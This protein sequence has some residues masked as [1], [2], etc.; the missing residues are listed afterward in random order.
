MKSVL[1]FSQG[2]F[3]DYGHSY[4]YCKGLATA[5]V[6][7]DYTVEVFGSDGP[8]SFPSSINEIR[9]KK[10]SVIKKKQTLIQKLRWGVSRINSHSK[11]LN[12]F[13]NYYLEKDEKPMVIFETFEYFSLAKFTKH[14]SGN[15]FCIFH[16][17]NFNFKQTSLIAGIYK[18]TALYPS[19]RIIKNSIKSFVH[20]E[21]MKANILKQLGK[22]FDAKI[23]NIPYGAP[24][25]KIAG[26]KDIT[27]YKKKLQVLEDKKILLSFGTLRSDKEFLPIVKA[28]VKFPHWH[29]IIAGPEGDISY[30][31]VL[32][33]VHEYGIQ[34][35]VHTFK[36]FIKNAEQ[37]QFFAVSNLVINI[38]KSFIRH[39]SGTAQLA[40]SYVKPVVVGGPPDL[41]KYVEEIGIGW[42]VSISSD[43]ENVLS[44][45][46]KLTDKELK[47]IH[48]NIK[49]LA[50]KNAWPTVVKKILSY[51]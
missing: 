28:L 35:Q 50:M 12:S 30:E 26:L 46:E 34:N 43:L 37:E 48:E 49:H 8:L 21:E 23:V 3:Q 32:Q 47:K 16:D 22:K 31:N 15:Y 39:E 9:A 10:D 33:L 20:G 5:L 29:W 18:R 27:L 25:P 42:I 17:T 6:D 1:I 24:E 2:A 40:R 11:I 4:D 13:T 44:T 41:I 45:Y 51:N 7:L 36:R 38:Y 14:F 19:K